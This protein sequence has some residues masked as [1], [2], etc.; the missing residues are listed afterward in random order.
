VNERAG[1]KG[2]GSNPDTY[3]IFDA[4][5]SMLHIRCFIFDAKFLLERVYI[6]KIRFEREPRAT[7][8]NKSRK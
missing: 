4:S 2:T 7:K 8:K 5:Y 3:F 1:V 6:Q